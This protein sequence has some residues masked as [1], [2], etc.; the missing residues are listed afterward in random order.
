MKQLLSIAAALVLAWPSA[1]ERWRTDG[2]AHVRGTMTQ[3]SAKSVT[4][5]LADKTTKTLSISTKTDIRDV[6]Q[7][8]PASPTSR[9]AT[10]S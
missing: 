3:V 7:A 4:V 9:S 2:N 5:Q 10:A 6:R 8:G 1:P